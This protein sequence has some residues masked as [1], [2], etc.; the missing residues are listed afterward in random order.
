KGDEYIRY[1][2]RDAS[3]IDAGYPK[4]LEGYW[5]NL[6]PAFRSGFDSMAELGNG[7]IYVT[8]GDEYI[9]YSDRDASKIDAG[10]PKKLEGY[11]GNL[12]P[13]FRSGFDSMTELGNGKIYVTK[14][15]EYI[16]Y[17]DRDASKIDEGY[18]KKL[19]GNWGNL[20]PAFKSGFDSMAELG[21]GKIYVTKGDEY[22]RYSD[23]DASK[24]DAGYP[25]SITGGNWGDEKFTEWICSTHQ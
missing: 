20:P 15:D 16:R 12:P 19:E 25:Q 17:S 13:A 3:K 2:D 21:N 1:S 7:K 6:P 11:W 22:I 4:K 9:R 8:K 14:G 18:P 24:I 5:G 23:R 10:Y